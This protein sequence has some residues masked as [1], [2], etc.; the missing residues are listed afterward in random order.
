LP[1]LRV[2]WRADF[3]GELLREHLKNSSDRHGQIAAATE[4]DLR[5]INVHYGDVAAED[6]T[7]STGLKIP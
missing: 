2:I 4:N 5:G 6:L 3:A 7:D 1:A